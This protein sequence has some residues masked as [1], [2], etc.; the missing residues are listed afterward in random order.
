MNVFEATTQFINCIMQLLLIR[1]YTNVKL[2][3]QV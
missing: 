2:D 3:W 1:L